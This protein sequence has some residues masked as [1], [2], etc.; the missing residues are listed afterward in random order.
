MW[1]NP[2]TSPGFCAMARA[3][4]CWCVHPSQQGNTRARKII[5]VGCPVM[6]SKSS[7]VRCKDLV[8]SSQA[9]LAT[10]QTECGSRVQLH[11]ACHASQALPNLLH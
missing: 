11:S 5:G 3:S 2:L 9:E 6:L 10:E 1:E 4:P 7:G 8:S